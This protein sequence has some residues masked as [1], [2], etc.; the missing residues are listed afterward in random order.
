M[1][2]ATPANLIMA[3][4]RGESNQL[5]IEANRVKLLRRDLRD[6]VPC[7]GL[8]DASPEIGSRHA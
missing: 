7:C 6:L 3:N 1:A 2:F 5:S 8:L 4:L